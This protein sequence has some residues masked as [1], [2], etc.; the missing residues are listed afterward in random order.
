MIG[1]SQL[2]GVK[3][4]ISSLLV[5]VGVV[6]W[7]LTM[8]LSLRDPNP[9]NYPVTRNNRSSINNQ[10]TWPSIRSRMWVIFDIY[11]SACGL[12]NWIT[13]CWWQQCQQFLFRLFW[14]HHCMLVAPTKDW[15]LCGNN[16]FSRASVTIWQL[17]LKEKM[18]F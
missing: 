7:Q 3:S 8:V 10:E 9:T 4:S 16:A 1:A 15:R 13:V 12:V 6:T 5:H 17:F 2:I 18:Q 14:V 11:C